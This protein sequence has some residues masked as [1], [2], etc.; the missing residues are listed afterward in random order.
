MTIDHSGPHSEEKKMAKPKFG[1]TVKKILH[2]S[3]NL[4][5]SD[6]Y[7]VATKGKGRRSNIGNQGGPIE[8]KVYTVIIPFYK[9]KALFY[10]KHRNGQ[11]YYQPISIKFRWPYC[12][13]GQANDI[14]DYFYEQYLI[15]SKDLCLHLTYNIFTFSPLAQLDFSIAFCYLNDTQRY[16]LGERF[17]EIS[18][19]D[20]DVMRDLNCYFDFI[21]RVLEGR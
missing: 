9:D 4:S 17:T 1:G 16:I 7:S 12:F 11:K 15:E 20:L 19:H 6:L 10:E 3:K 14:A 18:Q 8:T 2:V 13:E 5:L 21:L